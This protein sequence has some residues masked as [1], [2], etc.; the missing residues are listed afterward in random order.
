MFFV[1]SL[2]LNIIQVFKYTFCLQRRC[3]NNMIDFSINSIHL[4]NLEVLLYCYDLTLA[5]LTE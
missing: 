2:L 4:T 3:T 5:A 1:E